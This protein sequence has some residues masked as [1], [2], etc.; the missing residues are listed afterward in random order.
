M[1]KFN[2]SKMNPVN[3]VAAVKAERTVRVSAKTL[4][5]MEKVGE[6]GLAQAAVIM[7]GPT[8]PEGVLTLKVDGESYTVTKGKGNTLWPSVQGEHVESFQK[9]FNKLAAKPDTELAYEL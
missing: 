3:P 1:A 4:A 8:L 2:F 5:Q 9:L 7:T 6:K